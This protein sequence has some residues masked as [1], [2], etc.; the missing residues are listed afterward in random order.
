MNAKNGVGGGLTVVGFDREPDDI[1]AEMQKN[2]ENDIISE[3]EAQEKSLDNMTEAEWNR[4]VR[5]QLLS[6]PYT[7]LIW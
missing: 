4:R 2:A 6:E 7:M 1:L 3:L 5:A